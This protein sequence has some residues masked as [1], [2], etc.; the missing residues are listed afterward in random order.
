M[1]SQALIRFAGVTKT[2]GFGQAAFQALKGVSFAI[3]PGQFV[4]VMGPSG[5]GK[6]TVMNILGCLDVITS[7]EY[8][9]QG[10]GVSTL[11][12]NQRALLRRH[13]VGFVF[14]GF[15][16]L[17]RTSALENVELPLVYRG[18]SRR[19]RR[20][21]AMS[22]LDKVGLAP[23][24]KHHPAELSGGQQQRVAIARALAT[25]PAILLADEPTGNLDTE[26]SQE[27][28]ELLA[29]LNREQRQTI[30]MVTHEPDMAAY[31][32]RIIHFV[33]GLVDSDTC[34]EGEESC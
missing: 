13:H 5:S 10:I 33:D 7:G 30:L 26:R 6:S 31:G 3:H 32:N 21:A 34:S 1:N 25:N 16:L 15:N 2:Y 9:F 11:D 14:Q 22:A 12:R 27:I 24:A 8:F 19:E 28:M 23:W 17:A 4:S 18:V 20:Q 29:E